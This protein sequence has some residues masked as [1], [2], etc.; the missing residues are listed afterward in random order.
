MEEQK[1]GKFLH[2][3][4]ILNELEKGPW[5]SFISGFKKLGERTKNPMVRGVLDQLE[6]SYKTQMGYWKGGVVGVTGYGAG[7]ISRFS[8]L[9]DK[10]PEAAEFHTVRVQPPPGFHYSTKE[11]RPLLDLWDKYGSGIMS[12]HG[13]T[14]NLLLTGITQEKVQE[15][16]DEINKR[17][18]DLGGAGA[19]VRTGN[20][21]VGMARCEM[22]CYD[23]HKAHFKILKHYTDQMHRPS[24][25]YKMKF[26]FSG[27]PNDCN[28]SILRADVA[29]IGIFRDAI[30]V[31]QGE[32]KHYIE[33]L[34]RDFIQENVAGRCP[35][36][37]FHLKGDQVEIEHDNCVK[38]MHC[39]NVM[40]KAL[41]IGKQK[42]AALLL[43][44]KSHLKLGNMLGSM[45]IPF[46]KLESDADVEN[47]ISILD[48]II[49]W[50]FDAAL[51]HERIGE[52]I[53]RV[54][55]QQFLDAVGIEASV[56]MVAQPRNNP[57]FKAAY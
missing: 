32:V 51:D 42:G 11:L 22:A 18:W 40:T 48:R 43:G 17:G 23:T 25:P 28:N 38:C 7:I 35:T 1:N 6:Y 2:D 24:F 14:G 15:F 55:M 39:L 45:I 4:P 49:D 33:K 52:T 20:S 57:F 44:G 12:M 31:D 19:D 29:T 56:D 53:E 37:C 36:R 3:T 27:C 10:F 13:Q 8:M 9:P 30:Q 26:K 21:C 46:I 5:P 16:F 34:G 41:H 50:W 54:G 47:Y